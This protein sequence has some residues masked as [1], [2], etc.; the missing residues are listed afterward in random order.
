MP[1]GCPPPSNP[2]SHLCVH[3]LSA[4][5]AANELRWVIL[6]SCHSVHSHSYSLAYVDMFPP[7][8]APLI[9]RTRTSQGALVETTPRDPR[10][11][12]KTLKKAE[13]VEEAQAP[14]PPPPPPRDANNITGFPRSTATGWTDSRTAGGGAGCSLV[15]GKTTGCPE[16]AGRRCS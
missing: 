3:P 9:Q 2:R 11:S 8:P 6:S 13:V 14:L 5:H 10:N 4:Q 16:E 15:C 12:E 7:A 1:G